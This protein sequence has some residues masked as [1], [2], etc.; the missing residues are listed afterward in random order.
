MSKMSIIKDEMTAYGAE[1]ILFQIT[2]QYTYMVISLQ[3]FSEY[4]NTPQS[5]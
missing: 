1:V 2:K 3:T 5:F 4:I